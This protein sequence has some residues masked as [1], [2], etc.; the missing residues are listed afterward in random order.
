MVFTEMS[1]LQFSVNHFRAWPNLSRLTKSCQVLAGVT[2]FET[3]LTD[4]ETLLTDFE[5]FH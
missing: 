3:L 4:F 2:H 5:T 1:K